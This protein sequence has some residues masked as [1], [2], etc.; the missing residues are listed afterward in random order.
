MFAVSRETLRTVDLLSVSAFDV[1]EIDDGEESAA[2]RFQDA[3]IVVFD[4]YEWDQAVEQRW[5]SPSI[6]RVV[7]DDMANRRHDCELLVDPTPRQGAS[8]YADLIP[9]R[10]EVLEGPSFALLRPEFKRLRPNAL[11]RRSAAYPARI[12]IS[13]GLTDVRGISRLVTEAALRANAAWGIDVVVGQGAAS[14]G[15]L[16]STPPPERVR[17]HVDIDS[18]AMAALM[19]EADVAVGGGGGTSWER[20]CMGLPSLIICLADNQRFI[21]STLRD[22]GAARLVGDLETVT[23]EGVAAA[24]R[25]LAHSGADRLRCSQ[26]AASVVDGNGADRVC[27]AIK[28]KLD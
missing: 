27:Q 26:I 8:P 5:R 16:R 4:C 9:D 24:L 7:I 20:C 2:K 18:R 25:A 1:V 12:L 15:W 23:C 21:A 10:C 11:A 13:M 17:V 3:R 22:S 6:L 19:V 28:R 14:L